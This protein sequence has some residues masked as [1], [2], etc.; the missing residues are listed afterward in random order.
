MM[1]AAVAADDN[2]TAVAVPAALLAV[3]VA[4]FIRCSRR[5]PLGRLM[6]LLAFS[7][8]SAAAG[9]GDSRTC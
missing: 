5:T 3:V 6:H 2:D 4:V 9:H 7:S 1:T 8:L